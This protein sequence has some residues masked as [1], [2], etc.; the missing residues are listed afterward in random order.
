MATSQDKT[1]LHHQTA[2]QNA[3]PLFSNFLSHGK[4]PSPWHICSLEIFLMCATIYPYRHYPWSQRL[5][6]VK[7]FNSTMLKHDMLSSSEQFN[8]HW[9]FH[10]GHL[11]S[12]PS[13]DHGTRFRSVSPY[14][15][16][17]HGMRFRSVSPNDWSGQ[18]SE[19]RTLIIALKFASLATLC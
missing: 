14:P 1:M 9:T 7:V 13:Q 4:L 18:P 15:S 5:S 19:R 3:Q 16:Q 17:D 11:Q 12:H 10:A 2:H 8:F 6:S